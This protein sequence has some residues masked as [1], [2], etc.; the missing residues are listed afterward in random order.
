MKAKTIMEKLASVLNTQDCNG[1][2]L[3]LLRFNHLWSK[4]AS[5]FGRRKAD[6]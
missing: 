6:D 4:R 3:Q 5:N 2:T 1:S